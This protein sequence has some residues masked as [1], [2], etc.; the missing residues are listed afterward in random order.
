M[1]STG[2][3]GT[4]SNSSGNPTNQELGGVVTSNP[5][6]ASSGRGQGGQGQLDDIP[7][8]PERARAGWGAAVR[9][10]SMPG[11]GGDLAEFCP[12]ALLA[13]LRSAFLSERVDSGADEQGG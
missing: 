9:F 3:L 11:T 2:D 13:A 8:A 7:A 6:L 12:E 1:T 4:R 5:L 10:G